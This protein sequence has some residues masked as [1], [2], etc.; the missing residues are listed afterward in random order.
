MM[1]VKDDEDLMMVTLTGM[2]VR[3]SVRDISIIG[4]NTQGV[5]MIRLKPEDRLVSV[6][7]IPHEEQEKNGE[8]QE[9]NG[10]EQE[11]NGDA[12]RA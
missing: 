11:E 1:S 5:R 2:I 10:E 8:E 6:A 4:R 9:E 3:V 12:G 7:R